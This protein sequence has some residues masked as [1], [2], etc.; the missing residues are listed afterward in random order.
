MG[1]ETNSVS[2]ST[3]QSGDDLARAINEG[4]VWAGC[5]PHAVQRRRIETDGMRKS[6]VLGSS[7]LQNGMPDH[8]GGRVLRLTGRY[9]R[10]KA[11][12]DTLICEGV[13]PGGEVAWMAVETK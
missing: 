2:P 1:N 13:L 12:P 9:I 3:I 4:I 10:P 11:M 8:L 6:L 7:D 5:S